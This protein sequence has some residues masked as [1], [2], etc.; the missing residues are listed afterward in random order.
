MGFS[1]DYATSK[2]VGKQEKNGK[3]TN[4]REREGEQA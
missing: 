3:K 4:K 1:I 2:Y